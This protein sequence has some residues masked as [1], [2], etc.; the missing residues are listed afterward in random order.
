MYMQLDSETRKIFIDKRFAVGTLFD[1]NGDEILDVYQIT[2]IDPVSRSYGGG[3]L[4][5][6]HARSDDYNPLTD[7]LEKGI[8][9]YV[10]PG[11]EKPTPPKGQARIVVDGRETIRAGTGERKYTAH[12]Y[13]AATED[14]ASEKV[15]SWDVSTEPDVGAAVSWHADG[16]TLFVS[17][18]DAAAGATVTIRAFDSDGVYLTGEVTAKVVTML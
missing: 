8:C 7:N 6:L 15:V 14:A 16:N 18:L 9:D 11:G 12:F 4:L 2:D 13:H 5:V 3:H 10:A 1:K 17:A